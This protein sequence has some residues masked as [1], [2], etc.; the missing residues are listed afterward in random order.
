[1]FHFV[2]AACQYI[3]V[4]RCSRSLLSI[5]TS[6]RSFG[7]AKELQRTVVVDIFD[8]ICIYE[9][10]FG[11]GPNC[12]PM[13]WVLLLL[14]GSCVHR[15]HTSAAAGTHLDTAYTSRKSDCRQQVKGPLVASVFLD[16]LLP[17]LLCSLPSGGCPNV[18]LGCPP[19]VSCGSTFCCMLWAETMM[20]KD[21]II[22]FQKQIPSS[23]LIPP[24]IR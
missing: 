14:W 10:V 9:V 18:V 7:R 16:V 19:A 4:A 1:M 24:I 21:G 3:M 5:Q 11:R 22:S 8:R 15:Q 17:S 6:R 13:L 23:S 12:L 2:C 20:G